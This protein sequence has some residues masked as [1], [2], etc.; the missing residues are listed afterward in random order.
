MKHL[1]KNTVSL[2]GHVFINYLN[3]INNLCNNDNNRAGNNNNNNTTHQAGS[4]S[5]H[6]CGS[7]D[8]TVD[9][10]LTSCRD[11]NLLRILG[12]RPQ[13]SNPYALHLLVTHCTAPI[14]ILG[15]LCIVHYMKLYNL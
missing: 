6:L 9:H 7:A 10:L 5:C 8:E 1:I 14:V 15:R 13:E 11:A 12:V 3:S 4:S 2:R